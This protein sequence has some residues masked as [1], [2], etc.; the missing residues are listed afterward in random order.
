LETYAAPV[1]SSRT[2]AGEGA[3]GQTFSAPRVLQ[4][5]AD[6]S[7]GVLRIRPA[8]P[9]T[10]E[11]APTWLPDEP[12]EYLGQAQGEMRVPA[13]R[14]V[15]LTISYPEAWR[16]LSPL[17]RLGPNDLQHL[18]LRGSFFSGA[19][20]GDSCLQHIAHL[21]GLRALDLGQTNITGPALKYLAGLRALHQLIL[22]IQTDDIGLAWV[23]SLPSL[24]S[25]HLPDN[26]V[27]NAGL[28]SISKLST[29]TALC[30]GGGQM[31]DEG[32]V[33][34]AQLPHLR[35]LAL[36]GKGFTDAGLRHLRSLPRLQSLYLREL[37]RV[38]DAGM[39]HVGQIAGLQELDLYRV[40]KISDTGLAHLK[41]LPHL[42]RLEISA[43]YVTDAGL[44][45][46]KEIPTLEV[47]GLPGDR[48]T[49]TGL[50]HLA[51]LTRLRSLGVTPPV[52][53]NPKRDQDFYTDAGLK[54]LATL[55]ALE[56]LYLGGA[57]ITDAGVRYLAKLNRLKVLRLD[58]CR[59]ITDTGL[60]TIGAMPLLEDL[61]LSYARLT[62][63]GLKALNRLSNL[64][65]LD[66]REIVP[67]NSVL[68]LSG[69]RSLESLTPRDGASVA[70]SPAG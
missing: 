41:K 36:W 49:D 31:T 4:F 68:D 67:D 55:P 61:Q 10:T 27:T 54:T 58:G 46:L 40:T 42:R 47:L 63:S 18:I 1:D 6:R 62:F 2:A 52:Y 59:R 11:T 7:L 17:G 56:K 19:Q 51:A 30:V 50:G 14:A 20:P 28:K 24:Q 22:P 15:S 37:E 13:G 8:Q 64:K 29:L 57:G 34:V 48:I 38:T 5:P 33:H 3:T 16:D 70:R 35:H 69:L 23:A 45:H 21:T 39:V 9:E 60:A 53:A 44:A 25:L 12:W 26:R 32:L 65:T 43:A 66:I